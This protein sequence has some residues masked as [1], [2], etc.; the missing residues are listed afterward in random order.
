MLTDFQ[1]NG[2][3]IVKNFF[4]KDVLDQIVSDVKSVFQI[5]L[6]SDNIQ[7][8]NEDIELIKY[9]QTHS[10]GFIGCMR[11]IQKLP[12]IHNLGTTKR[13]IEILNKIGLRKPVVSQEPIIMLNNE[14]TSRK[15]G[16]WK[17]PVHQDWRS[18]QG[19]LNSITC[20]IGLKDVTKELGP[21]EI[22]PGSHLKGLL[23]AEKDDW[24]MHIPEKYWKEEDFISVPINAGDAIIFSQLLVHRSGT[25][26][27]DKM[28]YSL[29]YRYDDIF[30][31]TFVERNYP[32]SR[33]SQPSYDLITSDFPRESDIENCFKNLS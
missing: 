19:S 29:Q 24:Y 20:W 10:D 9:Y 22:I 17:T 3:V 18:R 6:E 28:R 13:V 32:N 7:Y 16:D 1:R 31:K 8:K 21:V 26:V 30:E 15:T 11:E 5:K 27:S 33:G 12:L 2:Y 25:N 23:P 4:A 14:E